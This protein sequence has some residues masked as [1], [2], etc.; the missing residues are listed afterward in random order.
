M[1]AS[2]L[3]MTFI[4]NPIAGKVKTRLGKDIGHQKAVEIYKKLLNHTREVTEDTNCK[5]WLWY[6]DY[7]NLE[8]DWSTEKFDK[9]LQQ[10]ES[11]GDR[12]NLAFEDAFDQGFKKVIII[13]SDCPEISPTILN[14]TFKLLERDDVVIGPAND[15]GYYLLA[16]RKKVNLFEE[17][18]W[19][20]ETVFEE[21]IKDIKSQNLSYKVLEELTDLD[22]VED[23]KKFP[24]YDT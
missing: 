19:S 12:M 16:M 3:V 7:I 6:G 1:S 23:L 17:K 2:N 22:T 9:K 21:T 20:E 5:R 14:K 24:E 13:G 10:G 8:D 11:L 18:T 15:G 4:K